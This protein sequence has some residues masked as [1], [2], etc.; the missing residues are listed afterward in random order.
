MRLRGLLAGPRPSEHFTPPWFARMSGRR[1]SR[2]RRPG[3]CDSSTTPAT[4]A[5][6][7]KVRTC[8]S[9]ISDGDSSVSRGLAGRQSTAAIPHPRSVLRRAAGAKMSS[10]P[11][12]SSSSASTTLSRAYLLLFTAAGAGLS[13]WWER[14][15]WVVMAISMLVGFIGIAIHWRSNWRRILYVDD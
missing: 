8:S 7:S 2:G 5:P 11:G 4:S 9:L 15:G 13:L 12:C 10:A 1:P 6:R 14:L 3:S